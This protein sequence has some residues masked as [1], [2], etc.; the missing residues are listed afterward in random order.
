MHTVCGD[1]VTGIKRRRRDLDGDGVRNFA[2][3]SGRGQLKEDLESSTIDVQVVEMASEFTVTSPK[4]SREDVKTYIE[5]GKNATALFQFSLRDQARKWFERPPAGS[6]STWE[7]LTTRFLAQF[8]LPGGTAKLQNDILVFQ[9]HQGE[10]LSEA[11]TCFK[12]LLQKFPHHGIDLWLQVQ[13]FYDHVNPATRRTIDHSAGGKLR[14]KNAKK[15]W[16]LIEDPAFYDNENIKGDNMLEKESKAPE[17]VVKEGESRNLGNDNK[18]SEL[19]YEGEIE[20]KGEWTDD[21]Q[22]LDLVDVRKD[23]VY[24]TLIKKISSCSLNFDFRIEKGDP[25]NL[26]IPRMIGHTFIANAYINLDLPMNVMSLAYYNAIRNQGYEYRGLNFVGI[27]KDMHV[28]MGNMSHVIDFT[29]LENVEANIDPSLSHV[30]LDCPFVEITKL[31]LDREQGL[32]TFMDWIK[33]VTFRTPYRD[34]EMDDL[35]SDGRDLLLSRVILS[36]DDYMRGCERPSDLESG[37]YKEILK[38]GPSY[39]KEIKRIDLN[40]C[41]TPTMAKTQERNIMINHNTRYNIEKT[42]SVTKTINLEQP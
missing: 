31:I 40:V 22:P 5:D 12:D 20:K 33:E 14:D 35:T 16:A 15:S 11:C 42:S 3:T 27:E 29:I 2:T 28:F 30:V 18:T 34:L 38:L 6:I 32:I 9:Q 26:K 10:S 13:I 25:S 37:F 4:Y 24:E 39:K 36:E 41:H 21:E 17:I 8:L 1:G 19:G 7:D 23:L